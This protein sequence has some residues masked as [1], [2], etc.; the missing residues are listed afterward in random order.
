MS[1]S[2]FFKKRR[3]RRAGYMAFTAAFVAVVLMVYSRP[4]FAAV[5]VD[6]STENLATDYNFQRKTWHD[7]TRYWTAFDNGTGIEFWYSADGSSWTQNAS[8]TLASTSFEFSIEGDS[9][10]LFIAYT[11]GIDVAA[12]Q[13]TSYPGTGFSWGG[14]TTWFPGS[15]PLD[16][17]Y[18]YPAIERD[19]DDRVRI[20][21]QRYIEATKSV[22]TELA[23]SANDITAS[24]TT[25]ILGSGS[26]ND[27]YAAIAALAGGDMYAAWYDNG[28]LLGRKYTSGSGWD[29]S[30]TTIATGT[31]DYPQM[32]SNTSADEAYIVY[33]DGNTKFQRYIDGTGWQTVVTLDSNAGNS[34]TTISINTAS[35]DLYAFWIRSNTIFYK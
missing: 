8:A 33:S 32:V 31:T 10:N 18:N 12:R 23:T 35:N 17:H 29:G 25:E 20:I 21:C 7:G 1:S 2:G 16:L 19:T 26:A 5:T 13:A 34:D 30:N 4:T 3:L 11:T 15:S 28:S 24:S 27:K 6:T 22:V 14:A 9:S